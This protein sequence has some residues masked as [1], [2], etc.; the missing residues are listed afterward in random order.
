M[1]K[2]VLGSTALLF[3]PRLSFPFSATV[4]TRGPRFGII[5]DTHYA[6]RPAA[7]TRYYE[8]SLAKMRYC[9]Q[10]LNARN[11]DFVVHL[12]DFK[13][14]SKDRMGT[15]TL[16]Y[17]RTVESEFAK[18]RGPRYHCIGNHDVDSITKPEF[19]ANVTNT[20]I[21]STLGHY[22]FDCKNI[23]FIVLDANYDKNG[24]DHYY[25]AGAD[26]QDTHIPPEQ[27]EWLRSDLDATVLPTIVFCHHPLVEFQRDGYTFHVG[28]FIEVQGTLEKSGKV[29]AVFHG[30][31][32][33]ETYREVND[34]HYIT[35]AAMVDHEG[36]ENNAYSIAS[37]GS[38]NIRIKGF[39][40]STSR[41]V[42]T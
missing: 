23:H 14:E 5:A 35:Q 41:I 24:K 20:G 33:E 36:L 25:K 28:N 6:K 29:T 1:S 26:W 40:R 19:L 31:V 37:I 12:G 8:G 13:D 17:L 16:K 42:E 38:G 15:A 11:L 18:F 34:I 9:V 2:F 32:H 7:G 22:S 10:D 30:H 21:E 4:K 27:L 3:M 39:K